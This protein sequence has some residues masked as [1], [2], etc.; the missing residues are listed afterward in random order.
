MD[1]T[2]GNCIYYRSENPDSLRGKCLRYPPQMYGVYKPRESRV[3]SKSSQPDV[4]ISQE[5]C[6]EFKHARLYKRG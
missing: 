4:K 2:C 1:N 3:F 5:S 6:G